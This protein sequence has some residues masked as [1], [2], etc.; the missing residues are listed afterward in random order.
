MTGAALSR[1]GPPPCG[2]PAALR[3]QP[4]RHRRQ[5]HGLQRLRA[6]RGTR[7]AT[8]ILLALPLGA[9]AGDASP[10]GVLTT[11]LNVMSG[12]S[13]W[14]PPPRPRTPPAAPARCAD[15]AVRMARSC[16]NRN[17]PYPGPHKAMPTATAVRVG[18]G[19]GGSARTKSPSAR[20]PRPSAP[21]IELGWRPIRRAIRGSRQRR[22]SATLTKVSAGSSAARPAP[23]RG[24]RVHGLGDATAADGVFHADVSAMI[25]TVPANPSRA[26]MTAARVNGSRLRNSR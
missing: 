15:H 10:R 7:R 6:L 8:P 23:R 17:I 9:D 5:R 13:A 4:G 25:T 21:G 1:R 18:A 26:A 24:C 16:G 2:G 19:L 3:A 14:P 12:W 20:R 11:F 22:H